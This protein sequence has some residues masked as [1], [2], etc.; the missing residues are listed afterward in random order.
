MPGDCPS[1]GPTAN[2]QLPGGERLRRKRVELLA[3]LLRLAL[4]GIATLGA[5]A[6]LAFHLL[7]SLTLRVHGF[8]DFGELASEQG[9]LGIQLRELADQQHA[10]LGAHLVAQPAVTLGLRGLP[11]QR[12]HLARDFVEDVVD[13]GEILHGV[14]EAGLRQALARFELGDAGGLFNDGAPIGGLA[15][16]DLADAA[17]L[18]DGV[19]F[20]AE[21]GAHEDVLNVAQTTQLA[22]E[23]ILA[24]AGTEQAAR[25]RDFAGF[26]STLEFAAANFQHDVRS[27]GIV[28]SGLGRVRRRVFAIVVALSGMHFFGV[29]LNVFG[30]GGAYGRLVPIVVALSGMHFFGVALNVFG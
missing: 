13:A 7:H 30:L 27:G 5:L 11:L 17:L 21:A 22:V 20:R 24:L 12:V 15:A 14:F 19:R 8:G 16:E 25:D 18:N 10:Q 28:S 23:Q 6:M 9:S 3:V 2:R 29:A 26:E 4:D 1:A